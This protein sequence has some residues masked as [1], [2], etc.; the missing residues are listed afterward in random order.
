MIL[1]SLRT[2]LG[3]T[4]NGPLPRKFKPAVTVRVSCNRTKQMAEFTVELPLEGPIDEAGFAELYERLGDI[5]CRL[6]IVGSRSSRAVD[7]VA[8]ESQE[9]EPS[10][11]SGS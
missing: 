8:P 2:E 3:M 9:P 5:L 7:A 10:D 11:R 1:K 4:P 6:G